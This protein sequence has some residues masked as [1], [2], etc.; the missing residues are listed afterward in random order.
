MAQLLQ[1]IHRRLLQSVLATVGAAPR[2]RR[3]PP[4]DRRTVLVPQGLLALEDV[5]ALEPDRWDNL[6]ERL[7]CANLEDLYAAVGGGAIRLEDLDR[8]LDRNR[9]QPRGPWLDD[10]QL[11]WGTGKSH[12]PGVLAHLAG[13]VSQHG[14]NI[15]RSVNNTLPEGGFDLRLVVSNLNTATAES[16]AS[17]YHRSGIEFTSLEV[18]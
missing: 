6:L 5:R 17:D 2:R 1:R 16:L 18:V 7:A 4:A 10:D 14:G 8:A 3:R 11:H 9:H 15:L 13:M 12:R